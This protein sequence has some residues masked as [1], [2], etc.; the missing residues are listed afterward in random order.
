[1]AGHDGG[2]ARSMESNDALRD[3]Y[4]MLRSLDPSDTMRRK[5]ESRE[6]E[7]QLVGAPHEDQAASRQ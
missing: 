7:L 4:A 5:I 6:R 1:M 3:Y 2:E